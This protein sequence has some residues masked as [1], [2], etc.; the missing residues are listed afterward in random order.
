M[1]QKIF[2]DEIEKSIQSND[3]VRLTL[4]KPYEKSS[5]L[6]KIKITLKKTE[7]GTVTIHSFVDVRGV[8]TPKEILLLD[9]YDLT[10]SYLQNSLKTATLYTNQADFALQIN[11]SGPPSFHQ[12]PPSYPFQSQPDAQKNT[13]SFLE[14]LG[15][16]NAKGKPQK[17]KS[18]KYKQINKFVETMAS[19][20]KNYYSDTEKKQLRIVDMGAGKGYL[21]FALYDFLVNKIQ[22]PAHI[23]GVEVREDLVKKCNDIA[24]K[25]GFQ[26]LQFQQGYIGNFHLPD[27][28][29]LIALHACDTATDDAIFKG[30]KADAD[31]IIC[32]PC[33]HKQV[34]KLMNCQTH[35]Q[36]ILQFGIHKD[37]TAEILTDTIRALIL[38]ENGYETTVA[39]FISTDHTGKN[40][41]IVGRKRQADNPGEKPQFYRKQIEAL[42]TEYGLAFHYLEKLLS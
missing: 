23:T 25:V 6:K 29:I 34:R 14:E 2:F 7:T 40:V 16:L 37:R 27:T 20:I 35:L 13:A 26:D 31:L 3:F 24:E 36:S 21:T 11:H 18:D 38:E 15:V 17:G 8:E 32:A 41:M 42:K 5:S 22:L 12:R 33:C 28:D 30:I 9:L 4:S 39:E 1:S 10:E 19:L